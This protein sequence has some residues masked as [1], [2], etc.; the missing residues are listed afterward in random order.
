MYGTI[1][2][3]KLISLIKYKYSLE[4]NSSAGYEGR[5]ARAGRSGGLGIEKFSHF[6]SVSYNSCQEYFRAHNSAAGASKHTIFVIAQYLL[7]DT[8]SHEP[9]AP[10]TLKQNNCQ[11]I[12]RD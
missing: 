7:H 9:V 10:A 5:V 8:I 6:V 12:G 1:S 11:A 2:S 4:K 3:G